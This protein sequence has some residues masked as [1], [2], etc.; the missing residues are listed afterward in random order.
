MNSKRIV[1]FIFKKVEQ[2]TQLFLQKKTNTDTICWS[3]R[4]LLIA[5]EANYVIGSHLGDFSITLL[6]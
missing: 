2:K 5:R 1:L 3:S 4:G 6:R